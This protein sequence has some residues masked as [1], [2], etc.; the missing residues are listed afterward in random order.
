MDTIAP[1]IRQRSQ[2]SLQGLSAK[3][4]RFAER[5]VKIPIKWRTTPSSK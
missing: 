1:D 2:Q 3:K 5:S 4:F